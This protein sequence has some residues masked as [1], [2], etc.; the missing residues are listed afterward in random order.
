MLKSLKRNLDTVFHQ[1][2]N[3]S[4]GIDNLNSEL[5]KISF[6]IISFL[7][8][9]SIRLFRNSKYPSAWGE[10]IIIPIFKGSKDR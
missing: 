1:K 3:E 5:F 4:P 8:K 9:L 6:D 10:G 7:L 2:N